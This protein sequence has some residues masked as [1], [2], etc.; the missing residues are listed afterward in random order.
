M[1]QNKHPTGYGPRTRILFDGNPQTYRLW[2]TK[3]LSYLY[4][5]HKR[6]R[7]AIEPLPPGT[8]DDK[9]FQEKNKIAYAELVQSLDDRSL[10]LIIND[11]PDD[12]RSALAILRQHYASTEKP[13]VLTL[14]EELTTLRMKETEDITDYII[15]ADSAATGLRAAGESISDN[16][17]IAMILKGLPEAYHPFVVIHTQLDQVK[18]F[19]EFKAALHNYANTEAI[20]RQDQTT[21]FTALTTKSTKHSNKQHTMTKQ[22]STSSSYSTHCNHCGMNN[23]ASKDCRKKD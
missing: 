5:L 20:R 21:Q 12:G 7:K 18:S 15:R 22:H 10:L 4:T 6:V 3:F 13:R 19:S 9:D 17:V 16:L 14:Y 11:S 1:A 2:E 8:S 23:H